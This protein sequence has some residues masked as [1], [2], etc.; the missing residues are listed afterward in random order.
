MGSRRTVL[1][2]GVI[3]LAGA[4]AFV[5]LLRPFLQSPEPTDVPSPAGSAAVALPAPGDA[6]SVAAPSLSL[7]EI[8]S[9][10]ETQR[11]PYTGP[12]NPLATLVGDR[13]EQ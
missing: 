3:A 4:L 6:P 9:G 2:P 12:T 10:I 8:R 7:A 13:R 11:R 5:V 1:V